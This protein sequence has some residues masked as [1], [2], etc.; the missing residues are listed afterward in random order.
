MAP[1]GALV[2]AVPVRCGGTR[3]RSGE[4]S[5]HL[6]HR[7]LVDDAIFLAVQGMRTGRTTKDGDTPAVCIGW[8]E[9]YPLPANLGDRQCAMIMSLSGFS[10]ASKMRGAELFEPTMRV[11]GDRRLLGGTERVEKLPGCDPTT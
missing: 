1:V 11:V 8:V 10:N 9:P 5:E 2:A 6:T 4:V 7:P 3:Q